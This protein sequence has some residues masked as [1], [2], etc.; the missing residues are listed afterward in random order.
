[1]FLKGSK[2]SKDAKGLLDTTLV[3]GLAM[4]GVEEN[5]DI[6]K[7]S[8]RP[9]IPL[10]GAGVIKGLLLFSVG[11]GGALDSRGGSAGGGNKTGAGAGSA[12]RGSKSS[13]WKSPKVRFSKLIPPKSTWELEEESSRQMSSLADF[14][15]VLVSSPFERS[16]SLRCSSRCSSSGDDTLDERLVSTVHKSAIWKMD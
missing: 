8:S 2:S 7:G 11:V 14:F 1:M 16:L 5:E 12:A 9:G 13:S 3:I 10:D 15:S 4:A 6:P